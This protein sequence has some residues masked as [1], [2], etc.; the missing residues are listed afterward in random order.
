MV[1]LKKPFDFQV[2]LKSIMGS[3]K[4]LCP[5]WLFKEAKK[6]SRLAT[7]NNG[8]TIH[9]D[10]NELL[11]YPTKPL[12]NGSGTPSPKCSISTASILYSVAPFR[13]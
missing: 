2:S 4:F 5:K 9:V 11:G 10:Y 13:L 6:V 8:C 1:S 12:D 7:V 3:A